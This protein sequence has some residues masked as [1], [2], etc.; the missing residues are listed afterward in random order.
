MEYNIIDLLDI[1]TYDKNATKKQY[2][3]NDIYIYPNP[4]DNGTLISLTKQYP[5]LIKGQKPFHKEEK[6]VD[7]ATTF[8][9]GS[10]AFIGLFVLFKIVDSPK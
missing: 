2:I 7:Y 3:G 9:I 5:S 1:N 8:F 4:Y 10:M 6:H